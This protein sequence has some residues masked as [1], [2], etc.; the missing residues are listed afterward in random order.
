LL[1]VL[2][3][4]AI[5][6]GIAV[7][8]VMQTIRN[9]RVSALEA[10][11]QLVAN[12]VQRM[13]MEEEINSPGSSPAMDVQFFIEGV[14]IL[15]VN[16]GETYDGAK[17]LGDYTEYDPATVGDIT[18][19][20][21]IWDGDNGFTTDTSYSTELNLEDYLEGGVPEYLTVL[22]VD[23]NAI[24]GDESVDSEVSDKSGI[25]AIVVIYDEEYAAYGSVLKDNLEFDAFTLSDGASTTVHNVIVKTFEYTGSIGE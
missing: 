19:L 18:L 22:V 14:D 6:A 5:V 7:P 8:R 1:A 11:M 15:N 16:T 17:L 21:Y 23:Q 3:I 24:D 13:F 25:G 12:T 20:P 2:A 10:E 9:A 4:L